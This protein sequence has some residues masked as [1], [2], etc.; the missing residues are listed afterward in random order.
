[1]NLHM[2]W[3]VSPAR[4]AFFA[5]GYGQCVKKMLVNWGVF[6]GGFVCFGGGCCGCGGGVGGVGSGVV[7]GWCG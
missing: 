1:M 2:I 4:G 7:F 5:F 6:G 3:R